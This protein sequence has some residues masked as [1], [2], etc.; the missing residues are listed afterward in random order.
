MAKS[1]TLRVTQRH[2]THAGKTYRVGDTFEGTQKLLDAF[3]DRL[4]L[5]ETP[6]N[7]AQAAEEAPKVPEAPKTP[8]PPPAAPPAPPAAKK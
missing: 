2:H 4:E 5:V 8:T 7:A 3:G 6:K 1:I